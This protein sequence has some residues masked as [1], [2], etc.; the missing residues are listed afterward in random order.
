VESEPPSQPV[1][2]YN[3]FE[4]PRI[5]HM[6][7]IQAV[8]ARLGNDAFIVKGWAITV[9]GALF[10]FAVNSSNWRLALASVVTTLAFWGLDTY[11]LRSERLFRELFEAIRVG[12]G[13]IEP[14]FMSATSKVFTD[15]VAK[16]STGVT[17]WWRT[18]WRPTLSLLYGALIVAAGLI[19][20]IVTLVGDPSVDPSFHVHR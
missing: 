17:S 1:T 5:K 3:T 12:S 14:F 18:F 4:G 7:M 2:R 10:G 9:A 13:N 20:L 11:F 16:G 19:I 8:I 15:V 6:E